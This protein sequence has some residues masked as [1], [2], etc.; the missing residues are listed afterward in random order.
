MKALCTNIVGVRTK[1]LYEFILTK[2]G[3]PLTII[4]NQGE[5]FIN[6]IIKYITNHFMLK[7]V[8]YTIDIHREMGRQTQLIRSLVH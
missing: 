1:F 4:T 2:F 5:H 8:S 6:D 7:C 3:C